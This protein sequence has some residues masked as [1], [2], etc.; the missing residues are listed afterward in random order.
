MKSEARSIRGLGC[1]TARRKFSTV[2]TV[3]VFFQGWWLRRPLSTRVSHVARS[4][5][6]FKLHQTSDLNPLLYQIYRRLPIPTVRPALAWQCCRWN[7]FLARNLFLLKW[8]SESGRVSHRNHNPKV[9]V[10]DSLISLPPSQDHGVYMAFHK[11]SQKKS[12]CTRVSN[13]IESVSISS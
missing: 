5:A 10:L 8:F 3:Q 9:P 12:Y 1:R 11:H 7:H 2:H 13:S 4:L 6:P